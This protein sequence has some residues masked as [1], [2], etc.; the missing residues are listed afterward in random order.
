MRSTVH[1][2]NIILPEL[3][4]HY[5]VRALKSRLGCVLVL[6]SSLPALNTQLKVHLERWSND[7]SLWCCIP[8]AEMWVREWKSEVSLACIYFVGHCQRL[9][10]LSS[11]LPVWLLPGAK[12]DTPLGCLYALISHARKNNNSSNNKQNKTKIQPHLW[13]NYS[14]ESKYHLKWFLLCVVTELTSCHPLGFPT[15]CRVARSTAGDQ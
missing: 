5:S 12:G 8:E 3:C 7:L 2:M 1:L 9:L 4:K 11:E 14:K 15:P 13:T 6:F 10:A